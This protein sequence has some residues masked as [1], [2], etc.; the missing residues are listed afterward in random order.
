MRMVRVENLID[1]SV[2]FFNLDIADDWFKYRDILDAV[3]HDSLGISESDK[4]HR[5]RYIC[6]YQKIIGF[7]PGTIHTCIIWARN[8]EDA[9][10]ATAEYL[11]CDWKEV[12]VN[13]DYDIHEE[14]VEYND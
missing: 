6:T 14:K 3:D 2:N 9:A 4:Q 7:E 10:K 8:K 11:G 5:I 13:I 1:K 12:E